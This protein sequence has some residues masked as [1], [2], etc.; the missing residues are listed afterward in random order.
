LLPPVLLG[1]A[2][3]TVAVLPPA[4]RRGGFGAVAELARRVIRRASAFDA[5]AP[6]SG[7][8]A[9]RGPL[10]RSLLPLA[11][12]FGLETALTIDAVRSGARVAEVDVPMEH[13]HT[14]RSLA[15]FRHRA[16]QGR[17]IVRA[18]WPRITTARQRVA[19][20]LAAVLVLTALAV[21]A[22]TSWEASSRPLP[23]RYDKVVLFGVPRLSL[24]DVERGLTPNLDELLH[25]QAMAA[26]SVRTFEGRPT[27]AEGYTALGA[28]ARLR[29]RLSGGQ[30]YAAA[31]PFEGG[32]AAEALVRRTGRPA[33]GAVAVLGGPPMARLNTGQHL[34]SVPG[35]LGQTLRNAGMR[36]AVIGNADN[37]ASR[38]PQAPTVYRPA[39]LGAMNEA[40]TVDSGA[41]S[42]AEL[43]VRDP[44]AP[45][46]VRADPA[47]VLAATRA[48]LADSQLVI[49]DPGDLDRASAYRRVALDRV[50]NTEWD[51]AVRR[52]D[53]MLGRV[54]RATPPRTLVMVVAPAPPSDGWHLM[55]AVV[56]GE[57][58][59]R[60][61]LHSPSTKRRAVVTITDVAPTILAELGVQV[62]AEMIGHPLRFH[63]A[64]P[65]LGD[66]RVIDRDAGY[67]ERVAYPITL[68]FIILQ[69]VLYLLT[70]LAFGRR[71]GVGRVGP[72]LRW[73]V[74]GIA[75]FPVSSFLVRLVP[76]V[77]RLG[78]GGIA[79]LLAIDVG[80]VALVQRSRRH[81]LSPLAWILGITAAVIMIDTATGVH[82]QT[83]SLLGY[84]LHIAARFYGLG[85]AA[86]AVLA[87]CALLWA[88][89]HVQYAP[90]RKEALVT[91]AAVLALVI[92]VDGAP[93][94]G[95]DVGGII[96][97]VPAF[98]LTMY[99]MSGRR[100]TWKAV[101]TAA[102][103]A[104][105]LLGVATGVDLLRPPEA[106]THLGRLV[107]DVHSNGNGVFLTTVL[108]KLSTNFR[109][110]GSSVWTWILPI[111]AVF[112]MYLLVWEARW[113]ELFPP[114][115][116]LRA[117]AVG[118]LATGLLGFAANDS[119]VIVA[120][121]VF[122]YIG[123]YLTLLALAQERGEPARLDAPDPAPVSVG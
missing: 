60:G 7:Q 36:T 76:D 104:V 101:L 120:A 9:V 65:N 75:A 121:L 117:G 96:T 74:L 98:G 13:A 53:A 68:T 85:N 123:P 77:A 115:S 91:A 78:A 11:D 58:I 100:V 86:F 71:G 69:A 28:G 47:K 107:S 1:E 4:G 31:A 8:R 25:T 32:T 42:R 21:Y 67:R 108:R 80:L 48:A 66:L 33:T 12:R 19:V 27:T 18:A 44:T 116:A 97:L 84:S 39:A 52:T 79:V 41:V 118:A 95:D 14:G 45:W 3:M 90:R 51:N 23:A 70:M 99:V 73:V 87:V 103:L 59:G 40:M 49:V 72:M 105:L 89:I 63:Q 5:R 50:A 106:R 102:G 34:P 46:G 88:A 43:L 22:G 29:G 64:R 119:G 93:S 111:V 94:L 10:L 37:P 56:T 122:V 26:M 62:P 55:P 92:I 110:L 83:S 6:L 81:P 61:Y 57:G 2:D 35:A 114:K 82:L 109:I 30:A 113:T 15:G 54:L 17:D 24:D 112:T 20:A 38:D 16:G